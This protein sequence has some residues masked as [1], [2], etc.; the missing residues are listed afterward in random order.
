MEKEPRFKV[1]DT[2]VV[3]DSGSNTDGLVGKIID[4]MTLFTSTFYKVEFSVDVRK[5]QI[6]EENPHVLI[7]TAMFLKHYQESYSDDYDTLINLALDT[8]DE[9]WFNE[10]VYRKVMQE[11]F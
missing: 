8:K 10:L 9:K 4:K 2:V 1:G 6:G 7:L 5:Y 3:V 11:V